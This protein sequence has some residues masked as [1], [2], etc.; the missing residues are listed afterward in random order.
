MSV[1]LRTKKLKNGGKSYYLDIYHNGQR[2]YEFLGIK[3]VSKGVNKDTTES[4]KEKQRIAEARAA[5]KEI[6]LISGGS[7]YIP[8]HIQRI[9]FF[10]FSEIYLKEYLK[11]DGRMIYAAVEKFREFTGNDKLKIIDITPDLMQRF[12][13]FLIHKAGLSG[14]TPHNY[15]TRFKKLLKSAKNK[16]IIKEVPTADIRFS[17]PNKG[18]TLSK[19]VLDI[20]EIKVLYNT[21]CGNDVVKRAFIFCCYTGLGLAEIRKLK[22]GHIKKNRLVIQRS[23]TDSKIDNELSKQTL[24]L[25]G[26]RKL[27]DNLVFD[28][29]GISDTAV[30]KNLKNWLRRADIEK[31][32]TFYC[33]RHSFAVLLLLNG[34]NLKS[35][36]DAMGHS[37]T[38]TTL[39]YL[40]H[41]DR[42]KDEAINNLPSFK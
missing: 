21:Y 34:A 6:E 15:I 16:G 29:K 38:K 2:S 20:D 33:A 36:A 11:K 32:I 18:D 28:L 22:W 4:R 23:K 14:E 13:D 35:V 1:K 31:K 42:L 7:N 8:R 30:N 27:N 37:S 26:K 12:Y 25:L 9:N 10:D 5:Q 40:N 39:K 41:V 17:N 3:T 24:S 19:E